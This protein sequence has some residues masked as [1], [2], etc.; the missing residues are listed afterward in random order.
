MV[1]VGSK[2]TDRGTKTCGDDGTVAMETVPA[3]EPP[4]ASA[5]EGAEGVDDAMGSPWD[6]TTSSATTR[7]F[8]RCLCNAVVVGLS[9]L[10]QDQTNNTAIMLNIWSVSSADERHIT[11]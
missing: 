8:C 6:R 10:L 4:S 11:K 2:R 3:E 5:D 1:R 9:F 7:R